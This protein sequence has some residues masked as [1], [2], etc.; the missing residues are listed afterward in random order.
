MAAREMAYECR[1]SDGR[2]FYRLGN[3]P[4]SI[5][6]ASDSVSGTRRGKTGNSHGSSG[7]AQVTSRRIPR[8]EACHE[9]HRAGAIGRNGH[10][11]DEHVSSYEHDLGR[12]PCK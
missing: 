1:V 2:L 8:D 10:E 3:C 4:H 9:I 6:G 12:D 5:P 7:A 11:F